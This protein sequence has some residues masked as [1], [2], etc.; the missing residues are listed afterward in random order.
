MAFRSL[1]IRLFIFP[2]RLSDLEVTEDKGVAVTVL[3]ELT[4][5]LLPS[6]SA[7]LPSDSIIEGVLDAAGVIDTELDDVEVGLLVVSPSGSATIRMRR[8]CSNTSC[9][10]IASC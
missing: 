10:K 7:P 9:V 3:L 2:T 4:K 8:A 1:E 6:P 5:V